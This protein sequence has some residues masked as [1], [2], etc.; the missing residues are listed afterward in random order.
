[1]RESFVQP[2]VYL[3]DLQIGTTT[4]EAILAEVV[5]ASQDTVD[6]QFFTPFGMGPHVETLTPTLTLR[7]RVSFGVTRLHSPP[8]DV[9]VSSPEASRYSCDALVVFLYREPRPY[10]VAEHTRTCST[11]VQR[12]SIP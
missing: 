8:D 10:S 6:F 12:C 7:R 1:M 11:P 9:I 5:L 3:G 2:W 4:L